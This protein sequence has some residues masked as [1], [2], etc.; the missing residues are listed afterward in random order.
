M[1]R[2]A[3]Q[4]TTAART[5]R[6]YAEVW[7][8]AAFVSRYALI[9]TANHAEADDLA[10]ETMLKA[11]RSIDQF[12]PGTNAESW[13]TTILR[14]AWI[15]RVRSK[16][17]R[18]ESAISDATADEVAAPTASEEP[19]WAEPEELL[20]AFGDQDIITALQALPDE[21]RWT[22]LLVDVQG[23]DHAEAAA[24]LAVPAGT[25]K[26]RAHRGRAMLRSALTPRARELG[27]LPRGT[28][29]LPVQSQQ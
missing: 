27:L 19:D 26:S 23:L 24:V 21:I 17:A 9:L 11:F 22:L 25:I 7:P 13:L 6:F 28:P 18:P 15:D 2:Q 5:R 4:N 3:A 14:H 29:A 20:F 16:R 1:S 10:Q 12:S 8:S